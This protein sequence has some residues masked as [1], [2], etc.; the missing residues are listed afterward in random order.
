[1]NGSQAG[2]DE[3]TE[4]Y[5]AKERAGVRAGWQDDHRDDRRITSTSRTTLTSTSR[6]TLTS[7]A[8][9]RKGGN[10]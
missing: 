5:I 7:T 3:D 4:H 9:T 6:T 8:A 10:E 2:T 1:V